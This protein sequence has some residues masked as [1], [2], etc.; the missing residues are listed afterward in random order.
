MNIDIMQQY[1]AKKSQT[2]TMRE[3]L[4]TLLAGSVAISMLVYQQ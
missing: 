3:T 2:T 1:I 4:L